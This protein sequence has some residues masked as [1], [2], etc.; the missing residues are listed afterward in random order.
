MIAIIRKFYDGMRARVRSG[1]SVCSEWFQVNQGQQ[2]GCVLSPILFSI[3]FAAALTVVLQ[4]FGKDIVILAKL[5]HLKEPPT[6][7][8]PEPPMDYFRRVVWGMLYADEAC[9]VS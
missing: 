6:S 2:Q 4:R 3:C 8:G 5:V 9:I 1:D 7:I